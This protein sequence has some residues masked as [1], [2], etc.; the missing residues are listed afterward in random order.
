[1]PDGPG[2]ENQR[3]LNHY[4]NDPTRR[5]WFG[6]RNVLSWFQDNA[7]I[8]L[9][10]PV[11][12][13]VNVPWQAA[14]MAAPANLRTTIS[15]TEAFRGYI[16]KVEDTNLNVNA[17]M[18]RR[19]P[20]TA[21]AGTATTAA[22]SFSSTHHSD[23]D[24]TADTEIALAGA[25]NTHHEQERGIDA[26][27]KIIAEGGR[28]ACVKALGTNI[29]NNTKFYTSHPEEDNE[30][31]YVEFKTLWRLW[32]DEFNSDYNIQNNRVRA[33]V[34]RMWLE[35]KADAMSRDAVDAA[36]YNLV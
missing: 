9:K 21:A 23:S 18:A 16:Y 10:D 8:H 15:F 12:V 35:G 1:V 6:S 29:T 36:D 14:G 7:D 2:S 17:T 19:A 5:G 22:T 4:T 3:K 25:P 31:V 32:K 20:H 26:M 33:V 30:V 13:E 27:T 28:F 11:F 34:R 24:T